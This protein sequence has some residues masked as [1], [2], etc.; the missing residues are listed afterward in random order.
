MYGIPEFR[1]P[2]AIVAG[3]ITS[4][5]VVDYQKVIRDVIKQVGY[6]D[7]EMGICYKTCAV[8]V[9]LVTL[10]PHVLSVMAALYILSAPFSVLTGRFRRRPHPVAPQ[11]DPERSPHAEDPDR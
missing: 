10:T 5:A 9:S 7:D 2:K 4:N 3:E 1:L 8:M 6:T 11:P